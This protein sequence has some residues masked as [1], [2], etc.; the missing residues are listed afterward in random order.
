[1]ERNGNGKIVAVVA[2]VVA[3]V[4]LSLGFAAYSTSLR[5]STTA[6]VKPN[7][8]N[9]KVGFSTDGTT[10][11][12]VSTARTKAGVNATTGTPALSGGSVDVTKY[13]I[14]QTSGQNAV[15]KTE[16]GSS[17]SYTLSI[18]NKGSIPAY[19]DAVDFSNVT[20]TCTNGAA[21]DAS[22][23][24]VIEGEAGAGTKRGGGNTTT[25]S[26]TDCAKMFNLTLSIGGTPYTS[27]GPN[28]NNT[29]AAGGSTPV[30]L[31]LAYAGNATSSQAGNTEADAVAATLDG[32][33]T[34]TAGNISVVYVSTNPN[35]SSNS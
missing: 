34:V 25:I 9:W 17:V 5:I 31:T 30:V 22:N 28:P 10:I 13:T 14:A 7:D 26:P 24:N 20:M 23:W 18:L 3:V 35:G 12:D 32:D 4:G 15:L 21:T 6:D 29:I 11:E 19:L 33:I 2:L 1:M 27:T 16:A 8:S